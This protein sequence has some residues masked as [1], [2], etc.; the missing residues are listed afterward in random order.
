MHQRLQAGIASRGRCPMAAGMRIT[1]KPATE[2]AGGAQRCVAMQ[3]ADNAGR[4][5]KRVADLGHGGLR[6]GRYHRSVNT[7]KSGQARGLRR[8]SASAWLRAVWPRARRTHAPGVVAAALCCCILKGV[9]D[10]PRHA[11]KCRVTSS[12]VQISMCYFLPFI[13]YTRQEGSNVIPGRCISSSAR[14]RGSRV[15]A[16]LLAS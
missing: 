15:G 2:R 9:R 10:L 6:F 4:S 7:S 12:G 16:A 1:L 8:I 3:V 5:A 11:S 14:Q 13:G